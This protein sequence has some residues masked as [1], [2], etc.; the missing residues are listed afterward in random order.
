MQNFLYAHFKWSLCAIYCYF[1]NQNISFCVSRVLGKKWHFCSIGL[2]G[3]SLWAHCFCASSALKR[4]IGPINKKC[5]FF[6]APDF[7][8]SVISQ[9]SGKY[10]Q[11][12]TTQNVCKKNSSSITLINEQFWWNIP[13]VISKSVRRE[14]TV[15]VECICTMQNS[16]AP[17]CMIL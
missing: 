14:L 7:I 8:N 3:A 15:L 4:A 10:G 12:I 1:H 13:W 5:Y 11:W 17:I 6:L 16:H 9:Y 2:Q